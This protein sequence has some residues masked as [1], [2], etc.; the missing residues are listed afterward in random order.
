MPRRLRAP[1]IA[2]GD[3]VLD[4][5]GPPLCAIEDEECREEVNWALRASRSRAR[6][7][8]APTPARTRV[9]A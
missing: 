2:D 7:N 6:A 1:D 4:A 5:Q 9:Y 3:D 8:S